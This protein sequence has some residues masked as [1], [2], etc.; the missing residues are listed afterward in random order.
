[1]TTDALI[2]EVAADAGHGTFIAGVVRQAA[3]QA[4]VLAVRVVHT[5][6]VAYLSDTLL[7]LHKV[8]DRVRAAQKKQGDP[9]L[10]IDVVSLSIGYYEEWPEASKYTSQLAEVVGMLTERGVVV[11]AAASN[12]ATTRE[13]FPAALSVRLQNGGPRVIG[14]GALNPDGSKALFSNDGSYVTCWADGV[15][16]VSTHPTDVDGSET[17]DHDVPALGRK[18]FDP[19]CFSSGF[20]IWDGTS[21]AAPLAASAV[22]NALIEVAGKQGPRLNVCTR[23]ATLKRAKAALELLR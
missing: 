14:V 6:G 22:L 19:D 12:N 2:G 21:F 4:R 5:D 17:P 9:D 23:S 10:M 7:L 1:M 11:L 16:V 15:C 20:A 13:F 8:L 3:P 18:G